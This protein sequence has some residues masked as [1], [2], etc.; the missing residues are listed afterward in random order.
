MSILIPTY[1]EGDIIEETLRKIAAALGPV[2]SA[3][4]EVLVVDDGTD[5]LVEVVQKS[6]SGMGF[7]A[8]E[9]LRN[10]PPLGKGRSLARGFE[11]ARGLVVG[12]LDADLSTPPSYILTAFDKISNDQTDVFI[13]SRRHADSRVTREQSAIKDVLGDALSRAVNSFIFSGGT[14]YRDTQCGFK[15]FKNALAKVL[16]QDLVAG[17]GLTDIEILIRANVLMLRVTELGVVWSDVRESKRS[18]RRILWGEL[19]SIG[20][21]VLHYKLFSE[22]QARKLKLAAEKI[23]S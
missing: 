20:A 6:K 8:I 13:G 14:K 2:L 4:T 3:K 17:D 7:R 1:N 15:F 16:Y 11:R 23:H 18:L 10:S 12:F 21:I 19:K 22:T 5:Q 9:V